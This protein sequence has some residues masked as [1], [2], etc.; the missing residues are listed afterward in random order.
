[1][2]DLDA[3]HCLLKVR[4]VALDTNPVSYA[5]ATCEVD[6]GDSNVREEVLHTSDLLALDGLCIH[7]LGASLYLRR[8]HSKSEV[9]RAAAARRS[10][11]I[12]I[13]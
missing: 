5:Q 12:I 10:G 7:H 1:V 4:G 11:V 6:A 8:R 13:A 2:F 9:E 3:V